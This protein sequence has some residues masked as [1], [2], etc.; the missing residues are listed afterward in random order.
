MHLIL[1]FTYIQHVLG[2]FGGNEVQAR[3]SIRGGRASA[4]DDGEAVPGPRTKPRDDEYRIVRYAALGLGIAPGQ[5]DIT[6]GVNAGVE[7]SADHGRGL[8]LDDDRGAGDDGA[9]CLL[10][11]SRSKRLKIAPAGRR[12]SARDKPARPTRIGA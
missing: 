7:R 5:L 9:G 2:V 8:V 4:G 12:R 6:E 10:R 1:A 3:P 11:F